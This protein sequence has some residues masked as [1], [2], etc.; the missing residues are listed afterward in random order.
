MTEAGSSI[1]TVIQVDLDKSRQEG[2]LDKKFDIIMI[3]VPQIEQLLNIGLIIPWNND[4]PL[5]LRVVY[6]EKYIPKMQNAVSA[7]E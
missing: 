2:I 5:Y 1:R 4:S 7:T 3:C 6:N